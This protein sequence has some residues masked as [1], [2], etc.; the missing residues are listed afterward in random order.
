ML[1]GLIGDIHGRVFHTIAAL[2]EWQRQTGKRF[3]QFIQVGDLGAFPNLA[4]LDAAT[5]RHLAA[6]PAEADFSRLLQTKGKMTTLLN[7]IRNH[8]QSPIYFV[9]GNHEDFTWLDQLT[10]QAPSATVPVDPF[11]FF[12][13][14]PDGSVLQFEGYHIAFLGGVEERTDA[15]AIRQ[16]PYAALMAQPEKTVDLLIS[17]QGPYGCSV[18]SQ[19]DIYGSKKISVLL[20]QL[21]PT[22][23][24][25]G[26]VHQ[27]TEPRQFG[28]TMY[29]GLT[30]IVAPPL[31]YPDETGFQSGWLAVLD[32]ETN[33][34]SAVDDPWLAEFDTKFDFQ[35]W[36][37]TYI[38]SIQN[39]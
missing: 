25:G 29:M 38:A 31:H 32:T 7:T 26:H 12:H 6:D 27:Y 16:Q 3:D 35:Q 9:R 24:V 10:N 22:F 4:K 5:N 17:H 34:I 21:K 19:G 8:L 1:I 15:A 14:V 11:D 36:V 28:A 37:E 23:H 33:T 2:L 30:L 39:Q 13:Y 20:D 18:S